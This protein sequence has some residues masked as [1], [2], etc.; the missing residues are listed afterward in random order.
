[1][2]RYIILSNSSNISTEDF[3][4]NYRLKLHYFIPSKRQLWT[5]I[6]KNNEYW[7]DP[8]LDYC[9]CKHYYFKTLS[10]KDKCQHLKVINELIRYKKYDKIEF[11]DDEYTNFIVLLIKDILPK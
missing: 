10:G 6:G 4:N 8:E 5:I 3:V 2:Y 7:L 11:S 9:S 1:M